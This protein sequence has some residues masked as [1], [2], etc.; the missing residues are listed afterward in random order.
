MARNSRKVENSMNLQNE[1]LM[2]YNEESVFVGYEKLGVETTVNAIMKD[3]KFVDSISDNGYLILKE[4][5][6]YA[7][8]GGQIA[9]S[10]YIKSDNFKAKVINVIKAPNKQHLVE[11]EIMEGTVNKGDVVLTHV[12]KEERESTAKNHSA[13][14]LLHKTLQEF[15]GKTAQQAGS[16]VTPSRLRLDFNY[17]GRLSDEIIVKIE[18]EV[19]NKINKASQVTIENMDLESAKKKGAMALFEDKY[20]DV[21]RVVTMGDSIELCGGTHVN[22]TSE[23]NKFAIISV[24]NKGADTFR[25]TAS[26]D[27]N[28][29]EVLGKEIRSEERRVGKE[30]RSRWSPYH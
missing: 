5:P 13:V 28:I 12:M 25:V 6:F 10:G 9:D 14:H 21:V 16:N 22:N 30:C 11:V 4:C 23:I 2:N 18:E 19:N 27:S 7:E 20:G 8:S 24:E 26:S 29:S 3:D 1:E 15:L 17:H